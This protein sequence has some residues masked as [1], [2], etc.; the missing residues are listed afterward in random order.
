MLYKDKDVSWYALQVRPRFEK[1][2]SRNLQAKGYEQYLPVQSRLSRWSDRTKAIELPLFPGYVFCQFDMNERL[3]ILMIP[4]VN[5]VVGFGKNA[6]PIEV[7]EL[8]GIRS[9]LRSGSDYQ[10]WPFLQVG[11]VV[12]VA[13]GPMEGTQGI[14]VRT[15][16]AFRLVISVSLLQRAVAVEIDRKCLEVISSPK[17]PRLPGITSEATNA[18]AG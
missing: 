5:S 1:V 6:T 15:K 12:R 16:D 9:V 17:P 7:S 13:Y 2:V 14:V 18:L 8:D 4:G 11:Q 3:P 10:P